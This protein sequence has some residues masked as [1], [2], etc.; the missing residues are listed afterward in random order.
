VQF[1]QKK[2]PYGESD[3]FVTG[4]FGATVPLKTVGQTQTI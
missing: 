1:G 3:L 4:V 2:T